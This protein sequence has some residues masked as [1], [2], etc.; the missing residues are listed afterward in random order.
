MKHANHILRAATV[1]L[2]GAVGFFVL[3]SFLVPESFGVQGSY[4][5]GFYRAD[6]EREKASQPA[7]YQGSAVCYKCHAAAFEAWQAGKHSGVPCETCHGICL[8]GKN[9]EGEKPLINSSSDAC[10]KCHRASQSLP[11]FFPQITNM[12]AHLQD[13]AKWGCQVG[14]MVYFDNRKSVKEK[15]DVFAQG[16]RCV[17]CH[18]A[19]QPL[20]RLEKFYDMRHNPE[21]INTQQPDTSAVNNKELPW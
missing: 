18:N 21:N 15:G 2:L 6:S 4:T 16:L 1:L 14:S 20:Q 13:V 9:E 3:R 11:A 7:L 5:Y 17:L 12:D 10:Q 19:H 8:N